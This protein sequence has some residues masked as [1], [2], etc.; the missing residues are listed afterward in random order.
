MQSKNE[1]QPPNPAGGTASANA[2]GLGKL[3]AEA[4]SD[5]TPVEQ[6]VEDVA[7]AIGL[8]TQPEV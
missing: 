5:S 6:K 3:D 8:E 2:E 4:E 7:S 1:D